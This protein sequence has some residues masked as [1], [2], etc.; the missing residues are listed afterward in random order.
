[1][2]GVPA[3]THGAAAVAKRIVEHAQIFQAC[4]AALVDGSLGIVV[5]PHGRLLAAGDLLIRGGKITAIT[6]ITNPAR[7][8][9]LHLAI[10]DD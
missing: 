3:E 7:L 10:P 6:T 1:P 9:Q 5:A 8:R 2:A 4:R